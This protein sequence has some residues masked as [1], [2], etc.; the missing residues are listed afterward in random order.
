[1]RDELLAF[2]Y[3]QA[4]PHRTHFLMVTC[5]LV[6]HNQYSDAAL[7]W[8]EQ[9]LRR[10]LD[11]TLSEPELTRHLTQPRPGSCHVCAGRALSAISWARP[12][13]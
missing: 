11:D 9:M 13:R 8:A 5:Y 3:A 4:V 10:H 1:L 6:Q 7:G 12:A 2:E